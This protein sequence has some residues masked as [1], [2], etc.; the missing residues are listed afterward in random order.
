M[1]IA[2]RAFWSRR[3]GQL[4]GIASDRISAN[5]A[6][7][8]ATDRG[9]APMNIGVI[10]TLELGSDLPFPALRA[11]LDSRLPTVRRLR[12]RLHDTPLG[13]GRAVWVDDAAFDIRRHLS[14]LVVASGGRDQLLAA[15]ATLVCTPLP[16]DRPL[17]AARWVVGLDDDAGALILVMHHS[18]TDGLG[19][20]AVLAAL[21][22]EAAPGLGVGALRAPSPAPARTHDP[23]PQPPPGR[24]GLLADVWR[25]RLASLRSAPTTARAAASGMRE[26]TGGGL[27]WR[28]AGRT[29]LLHPTG[30]DRRLTS[31]SVVLADVVA[32][33][34]AR[35][36][37]VNDVVLGAV[38]GAM[39]ALVR[40]RGEHLAVLVAS[41]P[42]AA[43]GARS[44]ARLGNETGV[45]AI[46]L[47]LLDDADER[48]RQITAL[49]ATRK[50]AKRGAS[51]GPLGVVFR[52]LATVGLFQ[53]AIDHQRLVHTFV[54]NVRGP[55]QPWSLAGLRIA[56][57]DPMAITPGNVG[58]SFDVLSYAGRLV[59]TLV[60]DPL[61]VPEQ[62]SLTAGLL[63][64]LTRFDV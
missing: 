63:R 2:R 18:L 34:H 8:L 61:V 15:A 53:K 35:G 13:C 58:V 30:P 38:A 7:T 6:T 54:T 11:L 27:R 10:L 29:S 1:R 64:E 46:P 41:S 12:Q 44:P 33:A 52:A 48:L 62:A 31:V 20:L 42:V 17:W 45:M 49:T 14:R 47:P 36:V 21:C 50:H 16:R 28:L 43:P 40:S 3:H 59:V 55:G 26:L 60:A 56:T 24:G 5:D 57:V 9:P 22:D 19:G 37:T 25:T 39:G 51:A 23:F 32:A 4:G